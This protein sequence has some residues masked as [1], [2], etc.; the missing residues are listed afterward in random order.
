M[1]SAA[2]GVPREASNELGTGE[3]YGVEPPIRYWRAIADRT[4]A[5][6]QAAGVSQAG[7]SQVWVLTGETNIGP[8]RLLYYPD[9][10]GDF[11]RHRI[12]A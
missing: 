8:R 2:L 1:R 4:V 6:A 9:S 11:T 3:R 5:E 12:R 7:E 10:R